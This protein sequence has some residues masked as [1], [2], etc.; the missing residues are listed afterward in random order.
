MFSLRVNAFKDETPLSNT[1]NQGSSN[2]SPANMV[3]VVL[4]IY[5]PKKH[6]KAIGVV[7]SEARF[8][9]Q[10]P[11]C[12]EPS[13]EYENPHYFKVRKS[14]SSSN[15]NPPHKL[16]PEIQAPTSNEPEDERH[17]SL[18]ETILRTSVHNES[19]REAESDNRVRYTY[20]SIVIVS[21]WKDFGAARYSVLLTNL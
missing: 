11:H 14:K 19:I 6:A 18:I 12:L 9:L 17:A 1:G 3:H 8:Y 5:G 2:P 4:D 21:F 13:K 20:S 15:W 16:L 7:L 10:H